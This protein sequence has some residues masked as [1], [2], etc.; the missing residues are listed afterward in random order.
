MSISLEVAS[1]ACSRI[2]GVWVVIS[3]TER[4]AA[5]REV[6]PGGIYD[7]R[8]NITA[9]SPLGAPARMLLKKTD[10]LHRV[11]LVMRLMAGLALLLSPAVILLAGAWPVVALATLLAGRLV[12]YGGDDGSDQMLTIMSLT[13]AV[14]LPL[15]LVDERIARAGVYFIGAQ[16][17]LAYSAAGIA[18]LLSPDWRSGVAIRGILSTRTY[19]LK[20]VAVTV[21]RYPA[22]A[23]TLAVA[24]VAFESTFLLAPVLPSVALLVLLAVAAMFHVSTAVAMGLNGFFWSFVATYPAVIFLNESVGA[25]L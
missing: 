9:G 11:L 15:G 20:R 14:A 17:C 22:L 21:Q 24:T 13:F 25:L 2:A 23:L 7:P 12:V 18:K 19:G 5:L 10:T 8:V 16:A 3:S 4:L 1:L 6:R